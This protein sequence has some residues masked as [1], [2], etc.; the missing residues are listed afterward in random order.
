MIHEIKLDIQFCDA[1][2]KGLKTFEVRRNDRGYQKGDWIRFIPI[3]T[4]F[5]PVNHPIKDKVYEITY[6]LTGWGIQEGFCV[7]AIKERKWN[8]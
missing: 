2:Y 6:V 7:F 4:L 3:G 8:S 5:Q 1:V